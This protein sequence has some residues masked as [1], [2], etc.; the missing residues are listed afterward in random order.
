MSHMPASGWVRGVDGVLGFVAV[1][2][3][4]LD[5]ESAA[6]LVAGALWLAGSFWFS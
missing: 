3:L 6:F 5:E 1:T 4:E 2:P